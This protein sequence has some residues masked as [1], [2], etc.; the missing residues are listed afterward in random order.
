MSRAGQGPD[1]GLSEGDYSQSEDTELKITS[2]WGGCSD[3]HFD[4]DHPDKHEYKE[5]PAPA[6]SEARDR[7][8][9]EMERDDPENITENISSLSL[10]VNLDEMVILRKIF[11]SS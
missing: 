8:F 7:L 1:Y 5:E 2:V 9:T 3:L 4:D 10:G 6:A 11:E